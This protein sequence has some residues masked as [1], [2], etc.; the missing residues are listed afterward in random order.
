MNEKRMK[1]KRREM[2]EKKKK[3][4]HRSKNPTCEAL[5]H[6][7]KGKSGFSRYKQF[8]PARAGKRSAPATH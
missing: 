2:K 1:K 6:L 4:K 5:Q 3:K 8:K 7:F